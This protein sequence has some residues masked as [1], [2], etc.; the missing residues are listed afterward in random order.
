MYTNAQGLLELKSFTTLDLVNS[1]K[2]CHYLKN[3]VLPPSLLFH[4]HCFFFFYLPWNYLTQDIYY[5]ELTYT[6]MKGDDLHHQT[7]MQQAGDPENY[8]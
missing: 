1:K 6:I 4:L 5:K 8:T 2:F 3:C 7:Y